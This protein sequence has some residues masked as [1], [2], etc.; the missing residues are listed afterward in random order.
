M[1]G[2][3]L[4]VTYDRQSNC[5]Y[6]SADI[7]STMPARD[8]KSPSDLVTYAIAGNI[9]GR[10]EGNGGNG[11]GYAESGES[12]TL[13]TTDVHAVCYPINTQ[14]ATR[15]E[16]MGEGTGL[17]IAADPSAAYT[18]QSAHSHAV[19]F[20]HVDYENNGYTMESAAGPLMKGSQSGGGR[21]QEAVAYSFDSMSSNSM[22]SSNPHSGVNTVDVAKTLD[23]SA[24]NPTCICSMIPMGDECPICGFVAFDV[25]E[26]RFSP[27]QHFQI[28]RLTPEECESLQ[29]FRCGYTNVPGASDTTRYRALGNSM[30]TNVMNYIATRIDTAVNY[31]ILNP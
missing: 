12:Y 6:G 8:Y 30:A 4:P 7:A 9:I 3:L 25:D 17:G 10:S 11:L 13:T 21:Q 29:G 22:K 20:G 31:A 24:L 27:D 18:L 14:I 26:M 2:H 23:T 28:R 19:A 15:H 16:A 1:N 5:E